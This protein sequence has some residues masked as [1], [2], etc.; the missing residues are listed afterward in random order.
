MFILILKKYFSSPE[1][2]VKLFFPACFFLLKQFD[3]VLL[4]LNSIKSYYYN[5]DVFNFNYGQAKAAVG[6][7]QV[8]E[9]T[10]SWN[11]G[12]IGKQN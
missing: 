4:Y 7:Y 5:D 2:T 11:Q 8:T 6:N 9:C 3:D 12:F 10:T 1:N